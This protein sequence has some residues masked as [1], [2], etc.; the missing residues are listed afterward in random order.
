MRANPHCE[1]GAQAL[2]EMF[3]KINRVQRSR[4]WRGFVLASSRNC[5]GP[6]IEDL[7]SEAWE[8]RSWRSSMRKCSNLKA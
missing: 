6:Q 5:E 7:L 3:R 8:K 2:G 4:P 1:D